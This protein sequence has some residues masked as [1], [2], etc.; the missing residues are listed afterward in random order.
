M[1][2]SAEEA[3][4]IRLK[5][6]DKDKATPTDPPRQLAVFGAQEFD[7]TSWT[8]TMD[9][10]QQNPPGTLVTTIHLYMHRDSLCADMESLG[11]FFGFGLANPTWRIRPS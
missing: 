2:L 7:F 1:A 9:W 10:I 8:E 3:E 4:N 6:L 5:N 11:D